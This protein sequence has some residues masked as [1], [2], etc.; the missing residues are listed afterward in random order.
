MKTNRKK[1][2][3]MAVLGLLLSIS[4]YSRDFDDI[5]KRV[6]GSKY[7]GIEVLNFYEPVPEQH[8][9]KHYGRYEY[10]DDYKLLEWKLAEGYLSLSD[11]WDF[12]YD[13]EREFYYDKDLGSDERDL[14][15]WDNLM[16]FVRD[17]GSHEVFGR[18][19]NTDLGFMWEYEQQSIPSEFGGNFD[20][21]E[22]ALRYRVRTNSDLGMG[23]TYWGFDFWAAKVFV[24]GDDGYSLEGNFISAT[25]WG[26][27]LQTFTTL[28]N[29]Y[30][31]WG[32]FDG[33][34]RLG[35]ET[36]TRWTHELSYNWAFATEVGI[37]WDKFSGGTTADCSTEF[38]VY[39]YLLYNVE[40]VEDLRFFA[41]LGLPG[42]RY[43]KDKSDTDSVSGSGLYLVV[44]A[45]F[46]YV[47]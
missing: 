41:E 21:S 11:K 43:A 32:N 23:G 40:I 14:T 13:I 42:Y 37:E 47:W 1:I 28:Y 27:G 39:P 26:Y 35:V 6:L 10:N 31:D 46:Q 3:L 16:G 36:Y 7:R 15:G 8:S 25:N 9:F 44:L 2:L 30:Y 5:Q 24:T 18:E 12:E 22:L 45:G 17:T 29:E 38:T 19:W 34:H 20:K 33:T 4:L